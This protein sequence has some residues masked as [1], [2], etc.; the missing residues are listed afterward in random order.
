MK[1]T[2]NLWSKTSNCMTIINIGLKMCLIYQWASFSFCKMH[3][4]PLILITQI[5]FCGIN[6]FIFLY[7]HIRVLNEV[8]L[9]SIRAYS[10]THFPSCLCILQQRTSL[11]LES[12]AP[13]GTKTGTKA[14]GLSLSVTNWE[15]SVIRSEAPLMTPSTCSAEKTGTTRLTDSGQDPQAVSLSPL[16]SPG[17]SCFAKS[18]FVFLK[19]K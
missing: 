1:I 15:R 16:R 7:F 11:I 6:S 19:H 13:N 12:H 14:R 8:W 17:N 4:F 2:N 9:Y 18:S 10:I 3:F 5:C